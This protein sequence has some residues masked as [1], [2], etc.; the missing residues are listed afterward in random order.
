MPPRNATPF[1]VFSYDRPGFFGSLWT[2]EAGEHVSFLGPTGSGKTTLSYQL[3]SHSASEDLPAVVL[4]MKPRDATVE[5]FTKA[6]RYRLVRDWPPVPQPWR[7]K[8]AGW[9][10][11]PRHTD[12]PD[13]DDIHHREVFRRAIRGNYLNGDRIVFADEVYSLA[14]ELGL[15]RDLI[16]VWS[17]G[18]SMG[19]GLWGATQKPTH[20]PL[21][22]Y[23]Q[24]EHLFLAHDPDRRAQD[25]FGEI[26]GVDPDQVRG[27]VAQ[28]P[29]F[30]WLYIRRADR[31]MCVVRDR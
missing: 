17:K 23:S 31:T 14:E 5:K 18:R 30:H 9:T 4:V 12:D 3:L 1:R 15:T 8:P 7:K 13:A 24:A 6:Q 20:V 16:R 29:K 22:M 27:I 19:C 2:Y 21:W 11:W 25:R 10:L 26:G 28:L